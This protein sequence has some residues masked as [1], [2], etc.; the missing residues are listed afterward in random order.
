VDSNGGI[1][2]FSTA[3]D[4]ATITVSSVDGAPALTPS[5]RTL[6]AITEDQTTDVTA[7][8]QTVAS[9]I[10]SASAISTP[11]RLRALRSPL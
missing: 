3:T 1:T 6:T 9:I 7:P 4:T 5:S 2:G 11:E 8:G 10:G